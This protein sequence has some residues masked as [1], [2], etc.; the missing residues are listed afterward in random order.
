[1]D[2][3]KMESHE[4]VEVIQTSDEPVPEQEQPVACESD[5]IKG[6]WD[7]W[8]IFEN[9]TF[10]GFLIFLQKSIFFLD[11]FSASPGGGGDRDGSGMP[12]IGPGRPKSAR[13]R[14]ERREPRNP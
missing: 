1:M 2:E 5:E 3:V 14:R 11:R 12:E 9:L 8:V 10:S 6:T 13:R 7:Y 4:D